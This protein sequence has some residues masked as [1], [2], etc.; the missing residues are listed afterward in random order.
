MLN[1]Y[2]TQGVN[3]KLKMEQFTSDYYGKNAILRCVNK[4]SDEWKQI[5]QSFLRCKRQLKHTY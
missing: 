5:Y 4:T 2:L 3:D 1:L